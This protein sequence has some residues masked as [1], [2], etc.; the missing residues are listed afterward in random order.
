MLNCPFKDILCSYEECITYKKVDSSPELNTELTVK[1][2]N[3]DDLTGWEQVGYFGSNNIY[4]KNELRRL[5][6]G[7]TSQVIIEY[8]IPG[9]NGNAKNLV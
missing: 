1:T 3:V 5:V 9:G 7:T 2:R 8:S 6:D 4:M